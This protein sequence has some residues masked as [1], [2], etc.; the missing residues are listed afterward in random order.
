MTDHL[1]Q[2]DLAATAIFLD[3]DGT[4]LDIAET[5]TAVEVPPWLPSALTK[6]SLLCGDALAILSGRPI[7]AID[8]LFAPTRLPAA[9]VHGAELRLSANGRV[10]RRA[11]QVPQELRSSLVALAEEYGARFEDKGLS[12]ALHYR[13][14]VSP[15]PLLRAVR[16]LKDSIALH[17]Y[18]LLFG[19]EVIELKPSGIDKGTALQAFMAYPPFAGRQPV[20]AG[21]DRTDD[22]AFRALSDL[23]GIG[24]SVGARN[25][26]AKFCVGTP[27]EFRSW[28]RNLDT[29]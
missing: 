23:G 8:E 26:L 11:E 18:D 7:E 25:S 21:D 22:D 17:A 16:T 10:L 6:L 19:K 5:P 13:E 28:L 20:F 14:L 2:L 15:A 29:K 12:V 4:L 3:V 1:P 24:I 9:G 27:V